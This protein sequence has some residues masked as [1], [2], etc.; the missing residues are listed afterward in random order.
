MVARLSF[1]TILFAPMWYVPSGRPNAGTA[2]VT[3]TSPSEW[4]RC[5]RRTAAECVWIP[6]TIKP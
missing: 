1:T 3:R 6:S 5:A 2:S 4:T